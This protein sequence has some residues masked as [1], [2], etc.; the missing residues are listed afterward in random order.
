[1]DEHNEMALIGT[2]LQN[3]DRVSAGLTLLE[4]NYK[5]MLY[6]VDTPLGLA[7]AKAARSAIRDPRYELERL[8]KK[9]KTPLLALGK[10]LDSEATRITTALRALE[11]PIH[12]Q[13]KF[14]E[15]RQEQEQLAKAAAEAARIKAIETRIN[16]IRGTVVAVANSPAALILDHIHD[17]ER[18]IDIDASFAEFTQQAS[19]AKDATRAK[20]KDLHAAAVERDKERQRI[21]EERAELEELRRQ[22]AERDRIAREVQARADAEAKAERDA[23][24]A[25]QAEANRI[26]REAQEVNRRKNEMAMQELQAIHH[27]LM[28][29]DTGRAPYCKGGDLHTID[30]LLTETEKWPITEEKFGALLQAAENVKQKVME[31]LRQKRVDFLEREQLAAERAEFE[32]QQ[33]EA[34]ATQRR[35]DEAKAAEEAKRTEP[36]RRKSI[37]AINDIINA[38]AKAFNVTPATAREWLVV[39]DFR[40]KETA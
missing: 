26:E 32:R 19:D 17:L 15:N 16:E 35:A 5:G 11:E 1:M 8:R 4:K 22:N 25:R 24:A 6:E 10:R 30:W 33:Q 36:K 23:E 38:V 27:Q 34:A 20:L 14:E 2:A 40:V 18:N 7:H 28:I 37:P 21:A 12:A 13:I 29:A 9:A 3:F 31:G 39:S